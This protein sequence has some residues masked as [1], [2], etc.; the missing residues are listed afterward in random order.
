MTS[1]ISNATKAAYTP[2]VQSNPP[3]AKPAGQDADGDSDASKVGE[4]EKPKAT[5]G[6]VG[7][8]I[9]TSA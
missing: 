3:A 2:P 6:S 7:T 9:N 1:A 4:T 5:S 8:I